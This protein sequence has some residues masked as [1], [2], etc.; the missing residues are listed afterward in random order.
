MSADQTNFA[1]LMAAIQQSVTGAIGP[2]R[3]DMGELRRDFRDYARRTD[4]RLAQLATRA[5]VERRFDTMV[6]RS[7]HQVKWDGY[8]KR[9]G[10]LEAADKGNRRTSLDWFLL[11]SGPAVG[12][13]SLVYTLAK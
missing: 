2:L 3:E 1:G 12:I 7:E 9:I 6:P 13:A 10:E 11:I 8:E 4:E 5:E